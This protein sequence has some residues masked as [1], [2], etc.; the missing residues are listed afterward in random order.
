MTKLVIGFEA[1]I[2]ILLG[3]R[4]FCDIV[5]VKTKSRVPS[6][7]LM[8][9]IF[10]AGYWTILPTDIVQTAKFDHVYAIAMAGLMVHIGTMFDF[11]QLKKDWRVAA[12]TIIGL[13]AMGAAVWLIISP[14]FGQGTAVVSIPIIAG[15]AIA[16]NLM[17]DAA[18]AAGLTQLAVLVA[19][20]QALQSLVGMP[21]MSWALRK[22][23][24]AVVG[25]YRKGVRIQ[26]TAEEGKKREKVFFRDRIPKRYKSSTYYLFT[27]FFI[28]AVCAA[29]S[30]TAKALTGGYVNSTILCVVFGM[31][32]TAI[33]ILD[34]EPWQKSGAYAFLIT[35]ASFNLIKNLGKA[36][37]EMVLL[38]FG[39]LLATLGVA[40]IAVIIVSALVARFFGMSKY[41]AIAVSSNMFMGFPINSIITSDVVNAV[42]ENQE[43]ISYLEG[44][45]MPKIILGGIASV[46]VASVVIAGVFTAML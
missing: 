15:G 37:V 23:A 30:P 6:M 16:A 4:L 31:V 11:E 25:D 13:V 9:V 26:T 40:A 33:G 36:T 22:E 12:V 8:S 45:F 7:L 19:M 38:N 24:E 41:M 44:V 46:S 21:I 20:I 34:V 29:L 2:A 35:A 1:A 32:L 42:G 28:G 43:E 39:P 14:I 27:T 18:S 3:I 5:S 17:I 10:L